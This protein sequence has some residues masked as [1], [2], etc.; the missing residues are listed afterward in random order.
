MRI[1]DGGTLIARRLGRPDRGIKGY[2]TIPK[3]DQEQERRRDL[4]DG[5]PSRL[6][7]AL[8]HLTSFVYSSP[9]T[10]RP[11]ECLIGHSIPG[12]PDLLVNRIDP[13]STLALFRSFVAPLFDARRILG[14]LRSLCVEDKDEVGRSRAS[15]EWKSGRR[16]FRSPHL[17]KRPSLARQLHR[18][19]LY[20][21]AQLVAPGEGTVI[22]SARTGGRIEVVGG[23]R[24]RTRLRLSISPSAPSSLSPLHLCPLL[25]R[26]A[27][28][29]R[30]IEMPR[31]PSASTSHHSPPLPYSRPLP[32][33]TSTSTSSP[34]MPPSGPSPP[35]GY[36]NVNGGPNGAQV[37]G[38]E[39]SLPPFPLGPP[40]AP[41]AAPSGM[42]APM[43]PPNASL[44]ALSSAAVALG[45]MPMTRTDSNT[46]T[47]GNGLSGFMSGPNDPQGEATS[48]QMTREAPLV[49]LSAVVG[50]GGE[51]RQ[52]SRMASGGGKRPG[53][54]AEC[55]R[56]KLG[57]SSRLSALRSFVGGAGC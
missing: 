15:V 2:R 19:H 3:Q 33:S 4:L 39:P 5:I 44:S 50:A 9:P 45:S 1:T 53:A 6:R 52:S 42:P 30:W 24:L 25:L 36:A 32:P 13:N 57:V 29:G 22:A 51:V 28:G 40:S 38:P 56:L 48:P 26:L 10:V 35:V 47:A 46:M 23:V 20:S 14:L 55:K 11:S 7:L 43:G 21:S 31:E 18:P 37:G 12:Q 27:S 17:Q 41:A 16:S 49:G 8:A 54:C 34:H